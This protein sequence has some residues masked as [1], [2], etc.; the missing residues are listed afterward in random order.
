MLVD[1]RKIIGLLRKEPLVMQ[2]REE[3]KIEKACEEWKNLISQG[4][5][6]TLELWS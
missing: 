1:T 4:W 3:L 2:K 6:V 5:R